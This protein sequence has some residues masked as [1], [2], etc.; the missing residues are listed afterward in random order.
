MRIIQQ[1][2]ELG[3][4]SVKV[5]AAIGVFDGLHLGHQQVLRQA[6]SDA[7]SQ[8]GIAVAI[9]FDRHPCSVVAPERTPPII[10]TL[11]QKLR[12]IE[13]L[14]LDAVILLKFDELLSRVSGEGFIRQLSSEITALQSVCVGDNFAFGHKRSGDVHLLR[15]LGGEIGFEVHGL[16]AVTLDEKRVS[17]TRVRDAIRTGEL[18]AAGRLL[19]RPYSICG[20]VIRGDQLGAS[21]GFPTA[22]LDTTGLVL[23][24]RGVYAVRYGDHQGVMNIGFRPTLE[25]PI[26]EQRVEVHLLDFRGDLYGQEME[27]TLVE[28][29]REEKKFANLDELR[30]QISL[31]IDRARQLL[32]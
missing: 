31:D 27:V 20:E 4:G 14:G 13:C 9:T 6:L 15:R 24:P 2:A 16:P 29:I 5:A 12:G 18:I 8:A 22:N 28:R 30:S 32:G 10:Y 1:A 26:P 17:S 3:Q 7:R 21:L 25:Q 11:S 19:G 23:P